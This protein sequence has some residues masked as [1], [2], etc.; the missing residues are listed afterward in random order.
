M[1]VFS[2]THLQMNPKYRFYSHIC[3]QLEES[4]EQTFAFN[5]SSRY[6]VINFRA[7]LH[8]HSSESASV[9]K[10]GKKKERKQAS[11]ILNLKLDVIMVTDNSF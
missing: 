8:F 2:V 1:S 5:L 4:T 10:I 7:L 9:D 11:D 6:I 3:L